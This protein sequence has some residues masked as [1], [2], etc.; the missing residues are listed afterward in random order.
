MI[1]VTGLLSAAVIF[2]LTRD[3]RS[4]VGLASVIY[5]VTK[6]NIFISLAVAITSVIRYLKLPPVSEIDFINSLTGYQL[7]IMYASLFDLLTLG[8]RYRPDVIFFLSYPG[9]CLIPTILTGR[10]FLSTRSAELKAANIS[11]TSVCRCGTSCFS[12]VPVKP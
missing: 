9:L 7:M 6:T 3:S 12:T 5:G 8:K 4:R 11:L 1:F 10:I 2:R